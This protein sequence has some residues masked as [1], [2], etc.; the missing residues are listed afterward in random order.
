VKMDTV[1]SGLKTMLGH[2][3]L[4]LSVGHWCA[5][6][7][8]VARHLSAHAHECFHRLAGNAVSLPAMKSS[9]SIGGTTCAS[10]S[11]STPPGTTTAATAVSATI[12]AKRRESSVF[13]NALTKM[14][15]TL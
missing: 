15:E 4:V 12:C 14:I 13:R 11:G 7:L 8:R 9:A 10:G 2:D 3:V 5:L 1:Q 6:A